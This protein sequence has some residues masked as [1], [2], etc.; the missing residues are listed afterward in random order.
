SS[1]TSLSSH[2][3]TYSAPPCLTFFFFFFTD[4]A[5]TEI[6]TLSL[7][8]ALPISRAQRG[9]VLAISSQ[10]FCASSSTVFHSSAG[11]LVSSSLL[12][13]TRSLAS[14]PQYQCWR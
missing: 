2:V 1:F 3:I 4:P 9:L 7:H 11:M 5:T 14:P 13:S 12:P 10:N 8:D 6:Y